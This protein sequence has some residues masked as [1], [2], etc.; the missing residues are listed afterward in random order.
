MNIFEMNKTKTNNI[1][2][3]H[4][5][6]WIP[7]VLIVDDDPAS[8]RFILE[9]LAHK[10]ICGTIANDKKRAVDFLDKGNYDLVFG[11]VQMGQTGQP[12]G[13]FEL[14]AKIRANSPELPV[15]MIAKSEPRVARGKLIET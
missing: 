10:G 1:K 6:D 5:R 12:L 14:L 9:I 2:K 8:A 4:Q 13:G 7:N 15:I 11:S 3:T